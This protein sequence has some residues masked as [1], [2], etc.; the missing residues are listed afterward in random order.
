MPTIH[1][2]AQGK[3]T[4]LW[5]HAIIKGADGRAHPLKLGDIVRRG[6]VILTTQD[7]IV[8]LTS[9]GSAAPVVIAPASAAVASTVPE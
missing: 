4:G 7:G 2:T 8:E 6:D 9:D 3:V 1:L 5:G